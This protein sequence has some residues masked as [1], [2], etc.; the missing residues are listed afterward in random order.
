MPLWDDI[1]TTAL[2][3][4]IIYRHSTSNGG[5]FVLGKRR[6]RR[7]LVYILESW[8]D[9]KRSKELTYKNL[10]FYHIWTTPLILLT[11]VYIQVQRN[12]HPLSSSLNFGLHGVFPTHWTCCC[13]IAASKLPLTLSLSVVSILLLLLLLSLS[14]FWSCTKTNC[15][16][17]LFRF[18]TLGFLTPIGFVVVVPLTRTL[19]DYY[20]HHRCCHCLVVVVV[21]LVPGPHRIIMVPQDW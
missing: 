9:S 19:Y 12:V 15:T 14:W 2:R 5:E 3:A 17:L 10:A 1:A 6:S 8:Y 16:Y 20:H 13:V 7:R 21:V 11:N 18:A 4:I